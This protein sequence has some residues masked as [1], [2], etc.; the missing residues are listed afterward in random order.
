MLNMDD[1]TRINESYEGEGIRA[2]DTTR[3]RGYGIAGLV[4]RS[5]EVDMDLGRWGEPLVVAGRGNRTYYLFTDDVEMY[6]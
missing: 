6:R 4:L 5:I 2:L 1:I 3:T